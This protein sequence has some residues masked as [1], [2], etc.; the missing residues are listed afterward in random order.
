M[1][2]KVVVYVDVCGMYSLLARTKGSF[3]LRK[4]DVI[5]KL[6]APRRLVYRNYYS[7]TAVYEHVGGCNRVELCL[8]QTM[9]DARD[10]FS[11]AGKHSP[12]LAC[13]LYT[14]ACR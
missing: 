10:D 12:P 2:D 1:L 13:F 7:T 9:F 4:K 8:G 11:G 6:E 14:E 3:L 5:G